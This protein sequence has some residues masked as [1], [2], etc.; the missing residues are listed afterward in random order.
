MICAVYSAIN[1][2]QVTWG[3]GVTWGHLGRHVFVGHMRSL[4]WFLSVFIIIRIV[5]LLNTF[6]VGFID[7]LVKKYL[8]LIILGAKFSNLGL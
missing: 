2:I 4:R 5:Q 1:Q 8:K 3:V 7:I 6:V